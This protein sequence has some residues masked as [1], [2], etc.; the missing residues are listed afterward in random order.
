[1]CE[2]SRNRASPCPSPSRPDMPAETY[3]YGANPAV[4]AAQMARTAAEQADF[5]L[6]HLRPGMRVLDAGCGGGS[7]TLGLAAAVAPGEV[8]GVDIEAQ[9][10]VGARRLAAERGVANVRFEPG[11][12]YDLP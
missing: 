9:R 1:M 5:F 8:V 12:I 2:I 7:I 4:E 3:T 11:D 10:L 6:P